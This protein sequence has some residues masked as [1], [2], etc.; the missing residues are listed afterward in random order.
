MRGGGLAGQNDITWVQAKSTDQ[1][2]N[3]ADGLTH[4]SM[5]IAHYF[6]ALKRRA[7]INQETLT[8]GDCSVPLTSS[9]R[10]MFG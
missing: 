1:K 4:V 3:K 2:V 5:N 6:L 10:Y 7:Y 8:D 9:L